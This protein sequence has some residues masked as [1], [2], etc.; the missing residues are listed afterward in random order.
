MTVRFI[1]SWVPGAGWKRQGEI[2]R[3]RLDTLSS[4]PHNWVKQQM[5]CN[6]PSL[7]SLASPSN[8]RSY[9]ASGRFIKSF[10]SGHLQPNGMNM[11]DTEQEDIIKW[12][13]GGLYAGSADTVI[14]FYIT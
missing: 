10:T 3:Q 5:V 2:W 9:Q 14:P 13:A 11:V 4:V 1:P 12:C 6:E 8:S 7:G